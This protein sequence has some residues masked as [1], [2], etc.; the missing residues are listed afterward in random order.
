M[1]RGLTNEVRWFRL[2]YLR[3]GG[4]LDKYYIEAMKEINLSLGL[5]EWDGIESEKPQPRLVSQ[6][7]AMRFVR[8]HSIYDHPE[9]KNCW[10][11]PRTMQWYYKHSPIGE[12]ALKILLYGDKM[13]HPRLFPEGSIDALKHDIMRDTIEYKGR[14]IT[15][16]RRTS[17]T[18]PR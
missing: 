5:D 7:K 18:G 14:M 17:S 8:D 12:E 9:G 13:V 15:M 11:D 4:F 16:A 1:K 6:E 2:Q 10:Y 3:D